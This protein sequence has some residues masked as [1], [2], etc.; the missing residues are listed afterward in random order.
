MVFFAITLMLAAGLRLTWFTLAQSVSWRA[1]ASQ[2]AFQPR[3]N[4]ALGHALRSAVLQQR[5]G[6]LVPFTP[7]AQKLTLLANIIGPI[8]LS[9]FVLAMRRRF[10]R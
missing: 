1:A 2:Q 8:Q 9:L 6:Y 4:E 5:G 3:L 7:W 10:R